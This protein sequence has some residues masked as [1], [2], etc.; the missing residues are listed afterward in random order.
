MDGWGCGSVGS[1]G[2]VILVRSVACVCV[3]WKGAVGH[4]YILTPLLDK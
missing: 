3:G 2:V 4:T 1:V